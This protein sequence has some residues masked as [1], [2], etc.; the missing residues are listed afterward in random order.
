MR[1]LQ[2]ILGVPGQLLHQRRNGIDA[3]RHV[4]FARDDR[5]A[6]ADELGKYGIDRHERLPNMCLAETGWPRSPE[7][8]G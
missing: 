2:E 8:R 6:T 4:G 1:R 5:F 7:T 3:R